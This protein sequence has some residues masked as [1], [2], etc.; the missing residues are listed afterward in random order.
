MVAIEFG[1]WRSGRNGGAAG[2]VTGGNGRSR[3][4]PGG[5]GL[6]RGSLR[7]LGDAANSSFSDRDT[8]A[9]KGR[10]KPRPRVCSVRISDADA[11][12]GTMV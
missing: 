9:P 2:S 1:T 4:H 6:L 10:R 5:N 12:S 8:R 7:P 11:R 3:E